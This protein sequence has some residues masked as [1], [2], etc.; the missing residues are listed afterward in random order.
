MRFYAKV[1]SISGVQWNRCLCEPVSMIAMMY[2]VKWH[3]QIL[4]T[5]TV[6]IRTVAGFHEG[7]PLLHIRFSVSLDSSGKLKHGL[8]YIYSSYLQ[9]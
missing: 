1:C 5:N 8:I 2:E 9:D 4:W 3:L 7:N 6:N